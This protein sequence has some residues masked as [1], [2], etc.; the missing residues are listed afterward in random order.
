M[1]M[2]QHSSNLNSASVSFESLQGTC[3][4]GI[5]AILIGLVQIEIAWTFDALTRSFFLHK[6]V[7]KCPKPSTQPLVTLQNEKNMLRKPFE[8]AGGM[9]SQKHPTH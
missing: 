7:R 8:A 3:S 2:T 6:N 9:L 1:P 5:P 4:K